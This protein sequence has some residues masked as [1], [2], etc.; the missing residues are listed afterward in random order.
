MEPDAP[1]LF[2]T[3]NCWP[4]DSESFTPSRRASGSTEP[5]GGNGTTSFTGLVG[6]VCAAAGRHAS[7]PSTAHAARAAR[8]TTD[9]IMCPSRRNDESL[10]SEP[11]MHGS[12]KP[13]ADEIEHGLH[14]LEDDVARNIGVFPP[15]PREFLV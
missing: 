13:T 6:H 1:G 4:S 10:D 7:A 2:S 5:P 8:R 14:Q 3:M 12:R 9:R 11:T 15:L